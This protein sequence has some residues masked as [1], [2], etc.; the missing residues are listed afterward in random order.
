LSPSS[1]QASKAL[2]HTRALRVFLVNVFFEGIR[3][4]KDEAAFAARYALSD[5]DAVLVAQMVLNVGRIA[6]LRAADRAAVGPGRNGVRV[7]PVFGELI[8][9]DEFGAAVLAGTVSLWSHPSRLVHVV[10]Q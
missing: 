2:S 7:P 5:V 3:A 10:P 6:K 8:Q 1:A 9:C 4:G